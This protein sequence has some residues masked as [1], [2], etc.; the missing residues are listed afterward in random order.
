MYLSLVLFTPLFSALLLLAIRPANPRT[1]P[2]LANL[3][4]GLPL[5]LI[6][7]L[8]TRL[9]PGQGP[10]WGV[11]HLGIK[12]LGA[13]FHLGVDGFS[14]LLLLV[15][16]ALTLLAGL[17]AT[18]SIQQRTREF[19]RYLLVLQ[20]GFIGA[21]LSL[22]LF[23]FCF[24]A[25]AVAVTL[26]FLIG[27]W[28]G[29]QRE[30]SATKFLVLQVLSLTG[31]LSASL[32]LATQHFHKTNAFSFDLEILQQTPLYGSWQTWTFLG[33]CLAFAL[34]APL[35][36]FHSWTLEIQQDSAAPVSVVLAGV[37]TKLGI[38]G[39]L[40]FALPMTPQAVRSG[41]LSILMVV[42]A[43][44]GIFYGGIMAL[45]QRE[46]K[47]LLSFSCLSAQSWALLGVLALTPQSLTGAMLGQVQHAFSIALLFLL[48]GLLAERR[49]GNL[50][51]NAYRGLFRVMPRF[52]VCL[53]LAVFSLIG[54]PG[55]ASFAALVAELSGVAA[56]STGW[57][58]WAGASLAIAALAPLLLFQRTAFGATTEANLGIPD[59]TSRELALVVPLLAAVLWFGLF[60]QP[61]FNLLSPP[62]K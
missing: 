4:L 40:R 15:S 30:E 5:L 43:A 13:R 44:T 20:W 23:L 16:V 27:I 62:V 52:T 54:I 17:S 42:C 33:F 29:E 32:I 11:S 48:A 51:I 36:P 12:S 61:L 59:L 47:K 26:Y 46:W 6:A 28:G 56:H 34:Q 25:V 37:M 58:I 18:A 39:L 38:Y 35:F 8:A 41:R 22:D 57:A 60:P 9:M 53:A 50:Q 49:A 19:Y 31:L 55:F 3:L 24:F 45:R 14:F 7:P 10:Q 1:L 2:R 21:F